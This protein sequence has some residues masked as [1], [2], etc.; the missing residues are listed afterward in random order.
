VEFERLGH[1]GLVT[2]LERGN[3]AIDDFLRRH[4]AT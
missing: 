4:A 1:R 3:A 2:H